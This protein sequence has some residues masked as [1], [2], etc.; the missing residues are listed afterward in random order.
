MFCLFIV[1]IYYY[2][3][4]YIKFVIL[5]R[6]LGKGKKLMYLEVKFFKNY[7]VIGRFFFFYSKIVELFEIWFMLE[8]NRS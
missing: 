6:L 7:Y 4:C 5:R 1:E 8:L 3:G 2:Y